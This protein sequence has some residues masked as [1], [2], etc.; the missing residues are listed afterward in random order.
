M[1]VECG[2]AMAGGRQQHPPPSPAFTAVQI[3]TTT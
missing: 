3:E 2:G 1:M